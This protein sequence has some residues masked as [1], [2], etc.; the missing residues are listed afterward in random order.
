[1][2]DSFNSFEAEA[3]SKYGVKFI[4]P[5]RVLITHEML[6]ISKPIVHYHTFKTPVTIRDGD[7]TRLT[8]TYCPDTGEFTNVVIKNRTPLWVRIKR[9]IKGIFG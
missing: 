6:G 3:P 8:Y 7:I 5:P 4:D 2:L 1:M 9:F